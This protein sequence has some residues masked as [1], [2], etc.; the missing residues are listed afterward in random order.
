[1]KILLGVQTTGNGHIIRSTALL[2]QLRARGHDIQTLFS[3]PAAGKRWD[4]SHF[5]PYETR[6]GMTFKSRSGH[7]DYVRTV[8]DNKPVQFIKDIEQLP[9]S[10]YD[11]VISDYEPVSAWMAKRRGLPSIGI[12]HLYAFTHD[13]PKS[14]GKYISHWVTNVFA[15]VKYSMGSHWHHFDQ[16]LLPPTVA[17]DV[18]QLQPGM[19]DHY[20]V[21]LPFEKQ[22]K[23]LK[24]L[25]QFPDIQFRLYTGTKT[26]GQKGHIKLCEI[27]REGFLNDL[28]NCRGVICNAGFSL[29]SEALHL[30]KKV[31]VKPLTGQVEQESNAVALEQLELGHG[32]PNLNADS[33]RLWLDMPAIEACNWPEVMVPLA[34]WISAGNWDNQ[35]TL[36]KQLWP[37]LANDTPTTNL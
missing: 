20:L 11:L 6:I 15:P 35:S 26:S 36:T 34:E 10:Q 7:I 23:V 19:G 22:Q 17:D 5:E 3:G 13:V 9:W 1:M 8:V 25:D 16:P 24:L 2:K 12:G 33:V 27:S 37:D 18:H 21:Y 29:V 14:A 28:A 30:G 32:M 4:L 31:L